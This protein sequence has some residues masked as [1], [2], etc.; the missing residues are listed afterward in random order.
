MI[1]TRVKLDIFDILHQVCIPLT[2][3][4][5]NLLHRPFTAPCENA[6]FPRL[7]HYRERARE[8]LFEFPLYSP[9]DA[10]NALPFAAIIA[11]PFN[12]LPYWFLLALLFRRNSCFYRVTTWSSRICTGSRGPVSLALQCYFHCYFLP[13]RW[14]ICSTFYIGSRTDIS[15]DASVR[16]HAAWSFRSSAVP[17]CFLTLCC[18]RRMLQLQ[19]SSFCVLTHCRRELPEFRIARYAGNTGKPAGNMLRR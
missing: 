17:S 14:E 18:L 12:E 13:A 19:R 6:V 3:R 11:A 15:A 1:R 9:R 2:N 10:T 5:H 4:I 16:A 8:C 7:Y